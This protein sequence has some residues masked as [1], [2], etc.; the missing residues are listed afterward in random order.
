MINIEYF[1]E[2]WISGSTLGVINLNINSQCKNRECELDWTEDAQISECALW[3]VGL[4]AKLFIWVYLQLLGLKWL[5]RW[6]VRSGSEK[7]N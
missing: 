6:N 4:K 3:C 7:K 2:D 5:L 1:F